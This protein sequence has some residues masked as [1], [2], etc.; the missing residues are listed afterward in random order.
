MAPPDDVLALTQDMTI[1]RADFLRSLPAAVAG[2]AFDVR[3]SEIRP[4]DA[5]LGW[6]IVLDPL[7]ELRIGSIRLPRHRV[8]IL[9]TGYDEAATRAFLERFELYFRRAGG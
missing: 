2:A 7:P 4:V 1:A 6:R 3:G 9:L 8:A 5:A